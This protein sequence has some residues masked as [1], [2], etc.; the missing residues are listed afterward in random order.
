MVRTYQEDRADT[1]QRQISWDTE[2]DVEDWQFLAD[3]V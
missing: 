2:W 3:K 1:E